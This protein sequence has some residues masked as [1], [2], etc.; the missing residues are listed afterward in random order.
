MGFSFDGA[1]CIGAKPTT[2]LLVYYAKHVGRG[3]ASTQRRQD[4]ARF[5]LALIGI[6]FKN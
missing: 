1:C 6:N 2:K 4:C 3:L 5:R